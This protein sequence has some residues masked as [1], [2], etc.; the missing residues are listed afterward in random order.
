[1]RPDR[2]ATEYGYI[3]PGAALGERRLRGRAIR[4]EAGRDDGRSAISRKAISGTPA[5]SCS[6][7]A[8]SSTNTGTS[9]RT[10]PPRSR[11][12]STGAGKDLGFVT[13]DPQAFARA[14]AKSVDY[15]VMEKTKRAA[16]MPVSYRLVGCRL[17]A[18]G[19]GDCRRR[20]PPAMPRRA[21]RCSWIRA[22][23]MRSSD[24]PL[25]ALFG[26]EDLVVVAS[27]DAVLVARPRATPTT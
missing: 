17:V 14:T 9:S 4:R 24:K 8:S 11:R 15:A 3:R 7:P 23:P 21:T 26:V 27:E 25:V 1:M 5:I 6:A 10:A 16:V 13:L 20:T 22:T 18:R 19:L 12:R 2:P